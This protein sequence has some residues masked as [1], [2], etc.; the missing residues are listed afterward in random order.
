[1]SFAFVC[2]IYG[3]RVFSVSVASKKLA[4]ESTR[5]Q[6]KLNE[7][8]KRLEDYQEVPTDMLSSA[9]GGMGLEGILNQLGIDPKILNNPLVRG[10]IDKYAPTLMEKLA[11]G[12][13]GGTQ[14]DKDKKSPFIGQV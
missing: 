7:A 3:I 10:F 14:K 4:K 6:M 13:I 9:I 5:L 11:S 12:E 8:Y 1:M 2:A